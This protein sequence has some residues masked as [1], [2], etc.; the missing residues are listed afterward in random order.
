M[1][2]ILISLGTFFLGVL[3][4]FGPIVAFFYYLDRGPK[5]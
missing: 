1:T 4:V 3:C 5:E 2:G